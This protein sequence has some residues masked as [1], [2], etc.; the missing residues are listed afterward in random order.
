MTKNEKISESMEKNSNAE[1][2]NEEQSV[3]LYD[4][5]D[6]IIDGEIEYIVKDDTLTGYQFDKR[7]Y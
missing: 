7:G 6:S 2:W 3:Q 1:K 4:Y 5:I